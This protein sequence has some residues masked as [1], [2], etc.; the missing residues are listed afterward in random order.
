MRLTVSGRADKLYAPRM[1]FTHVGNT[2]ED[3]A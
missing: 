2:Q 1:S 3:H